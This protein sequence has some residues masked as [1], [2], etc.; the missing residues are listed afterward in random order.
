MRLSIN[1]FQIFLNH[2]EEYFELISPRAYVLKEPDF[3]WRNRIRLTAENFSDFQK[4]TGMFATTCKLYVCGGE[5]SPIHSPGHSPDIKF[6]GKAGDD[7]GSNRSGQSEFNASIIFRD[8]GNCVFC[9]SAEVLQAAHILPVEC[10]NLLLDPENRS[11]YRID[12]INDSCNGIALCWGCHKCFDANLICINPVDHKLLIADALLA[13]EQEKFRDLVGV[14]VFPRFSYWPK[15]ELLKYRVDAME[16]ATLARHEKQDGYTLRC[17]ICS[18]GYKR[19]PALKK[20]E[21][22]CASIRRT[23]AMY[24]TPA[25]KASGSV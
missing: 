12:S 17:S 18:K 9:G 21:E 23:P 19:L 22:S 7:D 4:R 16:S 20:H 6:R 14:E 25:G 2:V 15:H 5:G 1:D 24:N 13:N 11:L 3:N 10:K 8:G